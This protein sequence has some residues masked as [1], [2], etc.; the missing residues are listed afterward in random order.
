V[1]QSRQIQL[2]GLSGAFILILFIVIFLGKDFYALYR[3]VTMP[4]SSIPDSGDR[5]KAIVEKAAEEDLAEKYLTKVE[6]LSKKSN[7]HAVT[8]APA[9]GALPQ[10]KEPV[11]TQA[12]EATVPT[13]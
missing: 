3:Q 5:S 11:A 8:A 4:E 2:F 9:A 7:L 13:P 6:P 10:K 12:E 1:T